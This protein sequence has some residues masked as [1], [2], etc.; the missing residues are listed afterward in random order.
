MPGMPGLAGLVS[1]VGELVDGRLAQEQDL[2]RVESRHTDVLQG[3]P[4]TQF[5]V[6]LQGDG[7]VAD[8]DGLG[9]AV[10]CGGCGCGTRNHGGEGGQA[11]AA[12]RHLQ[13]GS[14]VRTGH[15]ELPLSVVCMSEGEV[16]PIRSSL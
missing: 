13:Y 14:S 2:A 4:A 8:A 1:A 10:R 9:I 16:S 6:E 3:H 12:Q 15:V 7:G 5:V 11:R